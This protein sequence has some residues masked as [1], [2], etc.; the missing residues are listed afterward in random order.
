MRGAWVIYE[1]VVTGNWTSCQSSMTARDRTSQPRANQIFKCTHF[2]LTLRNSIKSGLHCFEVLYSTQAMQGSI[3]ISGRHIYVGWSLIKARSLANV[4]YA[5][6]YTVPGLTNTNT[7]NNLCYSRKG[8]KEIIF[9][10]SSDIFMA[11]LMLGWIAVGKI[12]QPKFARGTMLSTPT[13]YSIPIP[14]FLSAST[15]LR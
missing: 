12:L 15:A 14:Y 6:P 10:A 2:L 11:E 9:G 7:Y 4:Y 1:Y 8:W 5:W 13:F 3:F